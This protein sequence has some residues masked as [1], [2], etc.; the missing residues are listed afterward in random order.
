[1]FFLR[2]LFLSFLPP[3]YRPGPRHESSSHFLFAAGLSAFVEMLVLGTFYIKGFVDYAPEAVIPPA[4]FLEYF[5]TPRTWPLLFFFFDG[6]IRLL[7]AFAGQA[8]GTLPLYFAAWI[9][10]WLRR[11]ATRRRLGPLVEDLVE[12]GD[13]GRYELRISSCR[14]RRNWDKWMTV[15][16]DEK[17]YEIAGAELG[18]PPRPYVYLL[19]AKPESKVIRG[20]HRYHPAEVFSPEED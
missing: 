9:H 16:Y 4:A 10:A 2:N 3:F 18:S 20:L 7:T 8:I 19:R 12:R 13:G 6:G 11:R 17:L 14:P 5:F 15:M 1:M